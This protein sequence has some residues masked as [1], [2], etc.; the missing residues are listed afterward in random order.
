METMDPAG[1]KSMGL[2]IG[3]YLK[4]CHTKG[5]INNSVETANRVTTL[6]FFNIAV[7]CLL[8]Y[9]LII[10]IG[11]PTLP[12][13]GHGRGFEAGLKNWVVFFL[14]QLKLAFKNGWGFYQI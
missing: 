2:G 4:L 1:L 14:S 12:S 9:Q 3:W 8:C 7:S 10:I 13:R 5:R 6:T 11:S